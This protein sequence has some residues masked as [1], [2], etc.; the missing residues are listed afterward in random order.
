MATIVFRRGLSTEWTAKNPTLS[1]GEPGFEVDTGK[2]KIGNGWTP[3]TGLP[4]VNYT[5][6]GPATDLNSHINDPTPHPAYDEGPSLTL[7]YE[8]AKV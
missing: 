6:S 1:A 4:Y 2:C 3:W 8:N 5:P 7:L